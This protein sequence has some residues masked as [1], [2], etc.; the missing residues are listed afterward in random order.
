[1]PDFLNGDL[2]ATL[3]AVLPDWLM[4]WMSV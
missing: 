2:F 1:M 3:D 4:A